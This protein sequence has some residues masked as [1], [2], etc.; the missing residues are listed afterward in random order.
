MAALPACKGV[1]L[2][3]QFPKLRPVDL[4]EEFDAAGAE[5][6]HLA[7]IEFGDEHADGGVQL[8]QVKEALIAQ[9][10]QDPALGNL[11]GDFDFGLMRRK[12]SLD[13]PKD[14]GTI[15]EVP[16]RPACALDGRFWWSV[17]VVVRMMRTRDHR[18]G[19]LKRGRMTCI[20]WPV[21]DEI[22]IA[23]DPFQNFVI[24]L[25]N[26]ALSHKGYCHG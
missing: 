8:C 7:T 6:A 14:D 25:R 21:A 26:T 2:V 5:A 15:L 16:N 11:H 20:L 24:P 13:I 10:R 22:C 23:I 3:R 19:T 4:D 9:T 1:W 18:K 17:R 12:V